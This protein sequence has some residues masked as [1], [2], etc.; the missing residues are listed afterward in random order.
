MFSS[1]A[2]AEPTADAEAMPL[3][4]QHGMLAARCEKTHQAPGDRFDVAMQPGC[5]E[6]PQFASRRGRP[7]LVQVQHQRHP[8]LR[9]SLRLIEVARVAGAGWIPCIVDRKSTRLNSSHYNI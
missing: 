6:K 9:T 7:I 8:A 1:V 3:R 2:S 5:I 4:R